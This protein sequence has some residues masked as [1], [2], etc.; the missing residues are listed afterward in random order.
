V[1]TFGT[2]RFYG[3]AA[4]TRPRSKAIGVFYLHAEDGYPPDGYAIG[5]AD[6][7][8]KSFYGIANGEPYKASCLDVTFSSNSPLV[9]ATD[10]SA[11][12]VFAA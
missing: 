8:I 1:F 6:A 12:R 9:V 2:A 11:A 4:G 7:T 10:Q 3:S 5:F